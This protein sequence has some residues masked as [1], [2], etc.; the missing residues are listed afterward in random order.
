MG[1]FPPAHF[2]P[3]ITLSRSKIVPQSSILAHFSLILKL[4][5]L[6]SDTVALE[7][8][9]FSASPCLISTN[10]CTL[11]FSSEKGTKIRTPHTLPKP[12]HLLT[13]EHLD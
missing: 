9:L 13:A 10:F 7:G 3:P 1:P 12:E 6:L 11:T 8:S 5:I 4:F 2:Q